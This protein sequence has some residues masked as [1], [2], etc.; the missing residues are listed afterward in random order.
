M[1]AG[2]FISVN[3]TRLESGFPL[4]RHSIVTGRRV[5]LGARLDRLEA[6]SSQRERREPYRWLFR[7]I[8]VSTRHPGTYVYVRTNNDRRERT[9]D[10]RSEDVAI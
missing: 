1:D 8:V 10:T 7:S 2:H 6:R 3:G 4:T 9:R 5:S